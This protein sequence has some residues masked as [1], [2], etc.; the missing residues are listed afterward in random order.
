MIGDEWHA[1]DVCP[2]FEASRKKTVSIFIKAIP[3]LGNLGTF[4]IS[5]ILRDLDHY[6]KNA[7]FRIW[8]A[9]AYFVMAIKR[10]LK[11]P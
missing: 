2:N 8:K 7:R 11:K 6:P 1:L 4:K 3:G 9:M 10:S 5:E